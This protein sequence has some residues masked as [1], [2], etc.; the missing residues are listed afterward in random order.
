MVLGTEMDGT[1]IAF[2]HLFVIVTVAGTVIGVVVHVMFHLCRVV[3]CT[4][5]TA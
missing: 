4:F 5:G 3:R 1:L 2:E